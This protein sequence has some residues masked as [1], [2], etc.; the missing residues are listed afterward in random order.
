[1]IDAVCL[2][3]DDLE[4]AGAFWVEARTKSLRTYLL[5]VH[6]LNNVTGDSNNRVFHMTSSVG[7]VVGEESNYNIGWRAWLIKPTDEKRKAEPWDAVPEKEV[8]GIGYG[9]DCDYCKDKTC[10]ACGD[11]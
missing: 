5:S 6:V 11:E 8:V 3:P 9:W 10:G 4:R 2:C 1:M 7:K